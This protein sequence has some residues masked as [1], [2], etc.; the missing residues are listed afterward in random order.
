M[1]NILMLFMALALTS[2]TVIAQAS[3][4]IMKQRASEMHSLIKVDDADKHKEFI[5][6]NY[7]KKLLEKYEMERHT[8][9][10][11]MINKDFRDSKIVSMKPNVKEN[12]LLMLIE[13]IS[14][15]HQVTFDISY[16]PKDNYKING[17]G[18][19]AGEM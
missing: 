6:K 2:T 1:K 19:E 16:D 12:K 4:E 15:K 5:L 13:R 7:S 11:K 17:M 14:D 8:G 18:I 3:E 10:F 9:M